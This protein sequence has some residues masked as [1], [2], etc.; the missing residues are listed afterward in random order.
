MRMNFGIGMAVAVGVAMWWLFLVFLSSSPTGRAGAVDLLWLGAPLLL[1][2]PAVI[3][4]VGRNRVVAAVWMVAIYPLFASLSVIGPAL[5]YGN[6]RSSVYSQADD[7]RLV[8]LI[9]ICYCVLWALVGWLYV[10]KRMKRE[11][12]LARSE[13]SNLDVGSR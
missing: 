8:L 3:S 6:A 5:M 13:A 9:S 10:R 4:L 12:Q 7:Q 11:H 2:V 1:V